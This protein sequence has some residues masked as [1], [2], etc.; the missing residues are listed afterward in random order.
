MLDSDPPTAG[1]RLLRYFDSDPVVASEKLL[2]CRQK[3]IRRFAAERCHDAEDL[4]NETLQRVLQTLDRDETQLTTQ[5]EAFIAG[6]ATNVLRESW[7]RPILREDPLDALSPTK[8]PRTLSPEKL[9]FVLSEQ[10]D[11][12]L[13]LEKCLDKF[14]AWERETLIRYYDANHGEKLKK[15]REVMALSLGITSSQ[16]RKRAFNFRAKLEECIKNCLDLREQN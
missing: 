8:E 14:H 10:E 12:L 15:V 3:L 11:L 6:F 4:A 2:R 13:C 7:R 5:I 9:V 1:D 16:L